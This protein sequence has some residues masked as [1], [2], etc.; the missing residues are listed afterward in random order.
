MGLCRML[1]LDHCRIFG[2]TDHSNENIGAR[3][4]HSL[5]GRTGA[6]LGGRRL[7]LV[8]ATGCGDL[9]ARRGSVSDGAVLSQV[10]GSVR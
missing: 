3:R 5:L 10:E 9:R 6:A 1:P 2:H 8:R 4:R 7:R